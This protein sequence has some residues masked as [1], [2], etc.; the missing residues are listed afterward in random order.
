MYHDPA[1]DPELVQMIGSTA[2]LSFDN[3]RLHAELRKRIEDV[4]ESRARIVAAE[5]DVRKR[6][7]RD[8]HDGAQQRLVSLGLALRII[9]DR[10]NDNLDEETAQLLAEARS[11]AASAIDELRELSQGLYPT[12]LTDVGLEAAVRRLGDRAPMV[13]SISAPN[14]RF[15]A[16]VE[17]CAYFVTAEALTNAI[18]HSEA[19]QIQIEISESAGALSV[20]VR[21][22]GVGGASLNG[23]S[24]IRGLADRVDAAGGTID[25]SSD[26][27]GTTITAVIPCE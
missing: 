16:D 5:D 17:A 27:N 19:G 6:V 3:E 18:K 22:D 9:E 13:V 24:G 21:D 7:G 14:R 1:V 12:L 23:G 4:E 20:Q 25:L 15:A 11:E 10:A 8:L 26:V 2:G